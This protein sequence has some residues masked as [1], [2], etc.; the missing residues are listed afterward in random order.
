MT[1][2]PFW[3]VANRYE[4]NNV[5][6]N[7]IY[8]GIV[9]YNKDPL[10]IGRIKVACRGFYESSNYND[11]PWIYQKSTTFLGASSNRGLIAIPELGSK[12]SIEFPYIN[13]KFPFYSFCQHT[14]DSFPEEF[15]EDYPEC[16]GFTDG[17]VT[18]KVNKAKKYVVLKNKNAS[19]TLKQ[20][21]DLV[22]SGGT[23]IVDDIKIKSG[24]SGGLIGGNLKPYV[25]DH[26]LV[27][28]DN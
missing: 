6:N 15:K 10:K 14:I 17:H 12:V 5:G 25:I 28:G 23:L 21:G 3:N 18:F 9:V 8:E 4:N 22:Y 7:K 24:W 26:G 13:K 2:I 16:Y 19:L 27:Y 20:N 11:L 1:F